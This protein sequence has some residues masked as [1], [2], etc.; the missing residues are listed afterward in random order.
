MQ[1]TVHLVSWLTFFIISSK[2]TK[3]QS[4]QDLSKNIFGGDLRRNHLWSDGG[5]NTIIYDHIA[6]WGMVSYPRDHYPDGTVGVRFRSASRLCFGD[7][8]SKSYKVLG[9]VKV[10]TTYFSSLFAS[11]FVHQKSFIS[12][13]KN[14]Y[15]SQSS[16]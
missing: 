8:L 2:I 11:H 9:L 6:H 14:D 13:L 16:H 5:G 3:D 4:E 15:Y 12:F 1:I 10:M 7:K